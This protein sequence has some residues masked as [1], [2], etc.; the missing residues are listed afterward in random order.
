MTILKDA[1]WSKIV[2]TYLDEEGAMRTQVSI[3]P[4]D[5]VGK[6]LKM[7]TKLKVD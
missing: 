4:G 3:V 7:I 1:G 5:A 6:I 2:L